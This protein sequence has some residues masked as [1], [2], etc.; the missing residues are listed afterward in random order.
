M[1]TI[2]RRPTGSEAGD[3]YNELLKNR[4][5]N[6]E[7]APEL[8][9]ITC[10]TVATLRTVKG[11]LAGNAGP[12]CVVLNA[13]S[14]PGDGGAG[15]FYWH[16]TIAG[17]NG[18]S[19]DDNGTTYVQVIGTD[20]N[21][22]TPGAWVR[23]QFARTPDQQ[24]FSA[25]GTWTKPTGAAW[26]RV[27]LIPWGA[28]GAGG[29]ANIGVGGRAGAGSGVGFWEG[30][31][32]LLGA[33]ESLAFGSQPAGGAGGIFGG[34]GPVNGTDA[35][36]ATFGQWLRVKGGTAAGVGGYGNLGT[37]G[38]GGAATVA[39]SAGTGR[40]AGGGAGGGTG[41]NPAGTAGAAG[42]AGGGQ[43][44]ATALAGG[45]AGAAGTGSVNATSGGAGTSAATGETTGGA[46]GGGGGGGGTLAGAQP[47][48]AGGDGGGYGGGGGGGGGGSTGR[49]GAAGGKGGQC[50]G[51][52]TTW[53]Q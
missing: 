51:R 38:A 12:R 13:T 34:A 32:S 37:G 24:T 7:F 30:P 49:N 16:N 9:A 53:F 5:L 43:D 28:S 4:H 31:A 22:V 47:G 44:R 2:V 52:V 3:L 1:P 48:Q 11:D 8:K 39:G 19:I 17:A 42:G 26:V 15:I 20:G 36:D 23:M 6:P 14:T 18:A 29:A 35:P 21:F 50:F 27:E 33:T 41:G 10:D 40:A 25:S 46:G 45:T